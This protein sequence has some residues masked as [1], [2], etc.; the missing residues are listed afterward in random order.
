[1]RIFDWRRVRT[2]GELQILTRAS[3]LMLV[4]VPILAA[5]WPGVRYS[6]G[7]YN[8]WAVE[9]R[10]MLEHASLTLK[11][12]TEKVEHLLAA[13]PTRSNEVEDTSITSKTEEL[14]NQLQNKAD[15]AVMHFSPKEVANPWLPTVWARVFFAALSVLF[16]HLLYQMFAPETVR[17]YSPQEF[18]S[19][20]KNE[21]ASNPTQ[22]AMNRAHY[23]IDRSE[24]DFTARI[25]SLFGS[26]SDQLDRSGRNF[27]ETD[28][29]IQTP[30]SR[31]EVLRE[32]IDR[33]EQG[34][35]AEYDTL[36]GH[37]YGAIVLSGL[38]YTYCI[39]R[40]NLRGGIHLRVR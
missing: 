17:R 28:R 15:E 12:E 18:A 40:R 25:N 7:Q 37:A 22:G 39:S 9:T 6:L 21:Y 3:Y 13:L 14:L 36:S 38:L 16:A 1:M 8:R 26:K 33:V 23:Y 32:E 2:I 31:T 24:R 10:T 30:M 19:Q 35:F 5:L 11:L 29:D 4:V 20:M 34:A 27:R